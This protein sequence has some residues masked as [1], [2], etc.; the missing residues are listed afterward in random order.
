[1]SDVSDG[2]GESQRVR[3]QGGG[4][5]LRDGAHAGSGQCRVT[6]G[7]D[8]EQEA[9]PAAGGGEC[10]FEE[11]AG[12]PRSEEPLDEIGREAAGV[13]EKIGGGG[14]RAAVILLCADGP[15]ESGESQSVGESADAVEECGEQSCGS[16]PGIGHFDEA[17]AGSDEGSGK[18]AAELECGVIELLA[19][20]G[21]GG[22]EYLEAEVESKA[23]DNFRA[24][25]PARLISG[26]KEEAGDA[27]AVQFAG[28]AE[29]GEASPDDD[30]RVGVSVWRA[31]G[32]CF[33]LLGAHGQDFRWIRNAIGRPIFCRTGRSVRMWCC[34]NSRRLES[35][36]KK[37]D[38]GIC[39][40][41]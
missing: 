35:G 39:G 18:E 25:S 8:A 13:V 33:G 36:V 26:I 28:A 17:T 40:G 34:R 7:E 19:G 37:L 2:G 30:D 10:G 15:A 1:M 29:S 14:I 11:D 41:L 6:C 5:L 16:P 20:F 21:V 23:V 9:E 22:L 38:L 24:D 3:G 4:K 12:E 27:A 31:G 32:V